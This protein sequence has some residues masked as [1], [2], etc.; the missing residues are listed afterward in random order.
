MPLVQV[1]FNEIIQRCVTQK[2]TL[3]NL[4]KEREE[5][6]KRILMLDD[7]KIEL[8]KK[9]QSIKYEGIENV[10]RKQ[11]NEIEKNV[12]DAQARYE[13]NKDK[14]ERI[15][16]KLVDSKAGIEHLSDKLIDVKLDDEPN[17]TVT[18]DT[19]VESLMQ[20]EKK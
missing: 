4:K 9:L 10:T 18:D 5:F 8:K 20:I 7:E 1:I 17:I 11:I 13:K 3:E 6:E 16:K 14:L 15:V 19:L 12:V 2:E